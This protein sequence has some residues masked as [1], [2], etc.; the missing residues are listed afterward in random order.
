MLKDKL[1]K[2]NSLKNELDALRPLKKEQLDGIKT[3]YDVEFTYNSNA[4]EG[5]TLDYAE[6]KI[7]LLEGLTIGGKTTR[8]H[9]EAINH[10]SAIDYIEDIAQKK[11]KNIKRT[12]VLAI[13]RLILR[14]IDDSNAGS[15]R[16]Y[17]VYVN[18]GGG[19]KHMFPAPNKIENLMDNFYLWLKENKN[20]HPVLLAT[21]A[22][23]R[24]VSIHPFIDG[25]GRCARL[26]MNLIL[27]QKGYPPAIIKMTKRK[28]YIQSI[29]NADKNNMDEFYSL[30][31][32]AELES[33]ELYLDTVKNNIIW[34]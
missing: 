11:T 32:D 4:I 2:I 17:D 6:T 8:E 23:Y 21:E 18:K 3:M 31:S 5:S 13:H 10:K 19:E 20:M 9:L 16:A 22:H 30:I 1:Q 12:D 28:E 33:L 26:I 15:Y 25:N 7:I 29:Q 14:G 24:L 27:I 34:K